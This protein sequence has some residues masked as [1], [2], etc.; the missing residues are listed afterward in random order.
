MSIFS[1]VTKEDKISLSKLAEQQK[2]QRAIKI[3]NRVLKKT[4]VK[5]LSKNFSPITKKIEDV[6]ESNKKF[7]E[8]IQDSISENEN[9]RELYPVELEA[10]TSEDENIQKMKTLPSSSSFS[11]SMHDML[12]SLMNSRFSSKLTEVEMVEQM[13]WVTLFK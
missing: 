3:K 9:T 13:F 6:D 10:D 4:H 2:N 7:S 1:N 8:V 5:K 11:N 12:G